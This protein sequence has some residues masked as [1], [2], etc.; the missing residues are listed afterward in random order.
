M[1]WSV[2]KENNYATRMMDSGE[3]KETVL[4]RDLQAVK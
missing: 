1:Q 3:E 4:S 2:L